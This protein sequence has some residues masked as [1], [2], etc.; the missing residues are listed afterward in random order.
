LTLFIGKFSTLFDICVQNKGW[1]G[2]P[3]QKEIVVS[4]FLY[5]AEF[6][7][8]NEVGTLL[9]N[10]QAGDVKPGEKD[11]I[12]KNYLRSLVKN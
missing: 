8:S 9:D 12:I 7:K 11:Y 2:V 1:Y 5:E 4:R 3:R 6:K 10:D